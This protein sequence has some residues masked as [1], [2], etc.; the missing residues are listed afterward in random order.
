MLQDPEYRLSLAAILLY[1]QGH[2]RENSSVHI[3]NEPDLPGALVVTLYHM[4]EFWTRWR[5]EHPLNVYRD[6]ALEDIQLPYWRDSPKIGR[7]DPCPC[8]SGKKYKKC[9][10]A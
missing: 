7:N 8:G 6:S 5:A 9:C 1:D 3:E 2:N 4:A 10:A